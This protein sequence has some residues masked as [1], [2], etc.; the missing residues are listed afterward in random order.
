MIK[1]RYQR[2]RKIVRGQKI[3][4]RKKKMRVRKD[5]KIMCGENNWGRIKVPSTVPSISH[6]AQHRCNLGSPYNT[7]LF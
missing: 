6:R 2:R 4:S 7:I 3:R 1:M 5:K